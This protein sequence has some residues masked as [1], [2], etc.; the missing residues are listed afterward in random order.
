MADES[1]YKGL[2]LGISPEKEQFFDGE[3]SNLLG[4]EIGLNG[5]DENLYPDD[6]TLKSMVLGASG[7]AIRFVIDGFEQALI[8]EDNGSVSIVPDRSGT[9]EV[10]FVT[11]DEGDELEIEV[12]TREAFVPAM[13][14]NPGYDIYG[15]LLLIPQDGYSFLNT[16]TQL[17]SY[18]Y[19]AL[20]QAEQINRFWTDSNDSILRK[21]FAD[22]TGIEAVNRIFE[23]ITDSNKIKNIRVYPYSLTGRQLITEQKLTNND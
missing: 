2:V 3:T 18:D 19:P 16:G 1:T 7:L 6:S 15:N 20:K 8:P 21:D 11:Y 5:S 4:V 12:L 22:F 13:L 23:D 9:L 17:E 14:N 10:E